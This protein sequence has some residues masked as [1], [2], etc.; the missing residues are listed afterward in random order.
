MSICGPSGDQSQAMR[1]AVGVLACRTSRPVGYDCQKF[2]TRTASPPPRS[3]TNPK[4]DARLPAAEE[5]QVLLGLVR[6]TIVKPSGFG[7]ES[8]KSSQIAFCANGP[9]PVKGC[10][11]SCAT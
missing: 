5:I 9:R 10:P 11:V 8:L 3:P 4:P 1:S 7:C 6:F 2:F